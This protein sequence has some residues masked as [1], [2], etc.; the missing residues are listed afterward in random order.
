MPFK[1]AILSCLCSLVTSCLPRPFPS[2]FV[3]LHEIDP[4]IVQSVRY[5]GFENFL[6]RPAPGYKKPKIILTRSAA[7]ALKNVQKV[8]QSKGYSLIVYDGYR[9]QHTVDAWVLWSQVSSDQVAKELYYPTITKTEA[10]RLGYIAKKSAHSRGSTV[11]LSLIRLGKQFHPTVLS[12]RKL[13]NGEE[14]PFLDDGSVDMGSSFDLFHEV[15]HHDSPLVNKNATEKRNFLRRTM[16]QNG[17]KE[18]S[19]EW[20]HYTLE[21]EPFPGTYFNFPIR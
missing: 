14:I 21:K 5:C 17:F 3:Y 15:S 13:P 9:P 12:H 8:M 19:T 10:F 1:K 20:W 6:G 4:T 18:F 11:D 2:E 16:L 7:E